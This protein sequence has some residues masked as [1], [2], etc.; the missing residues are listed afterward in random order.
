MK[1]SF[2]RLAFFVPAQIL[3][4][5]LSAPVI[6]FAPLRLCGNLFFRSP[7]SKLS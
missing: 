5:I 3:L 1:A 7:W 2:D 6:S 4:R